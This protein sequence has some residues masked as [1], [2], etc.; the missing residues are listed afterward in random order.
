MLIKFILFHLLPVPTVLH[1]EFPKKIS[2]FVLIFRLICTSETFQ[3]QV[4]L[5]FSVLSVH[6][7]CLIP[8]H[9]AYFVGSCPP[10]Q[11]RNKILEEKTFV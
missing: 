7:L 1:P 4:L 6:I 8:C 11:E 5:Q 9:H 10:A 2:R 3:C